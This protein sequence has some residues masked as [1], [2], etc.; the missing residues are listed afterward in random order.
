M[1]ERIDIVPG[2]NYKII[3]NKSNFSYGTDAIFLSDF[4]KPKGLIM[5]LGTGTGIIPLRLIDKGSID[6]IYGVEIQ[7]EVVN[8]AQMSIELNGLEDKIKILHMDIK[9][10][11]K[12]FGK[13]TF[14]VVTT[15]PPYMKTG[16][17]IINA[18]ENFAISRHEIA[19]NLEDIVK[20]ANYL[21]KP[22]GKF[23]MVHRPDR[24]VDILYT[25]RQYKIE[26]KYIRFVQPKINK[27]PNLLLIEGLKDGKK[28]LKFYDPLIVYN[29]DGTYTDEIYKIYNIVKN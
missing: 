10:L 1:K 13:N 17:A 25:M 6:T 5:D 28:D 18:D 16:G 4:T 21:L 3:Q 24:L 22:L 11:N 29:E 19:C 8:L 12:K 27:K 2:T 15:N 20:T 7:E 26:P 23:Y 14:D 9:E